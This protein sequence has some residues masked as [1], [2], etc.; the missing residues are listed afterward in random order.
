[1]PPETKVTQ[2]PPVVQQ[3]PPVVQQHETP[4]VRNVPPA[5]KEQ[6]PVVRKEPPVAKKEPPAETPTRDT[7]GYVRQTPTRTRPSNPP[8]QRTEQ[9]PASPA[10]THPAG[11]SSTEDE[12]ELTVYTVKRGE[13]MTMIAKQ[14]NVSVEQIL[15]WNLL[16]SI[17]VKPGQ[18]LYIYLKK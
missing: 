1:M 14:F 18:E 8:P 6:A 10:K 2:Q 12:G 11:K 13:T 16:K 3:K 15:K 9:A 5:V 4:V 7:T 17:S